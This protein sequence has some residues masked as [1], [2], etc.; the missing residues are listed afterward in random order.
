[1]PRMKETILL[2]MGLIHYSAFPVRAWAAIGRGLFQKTFSRSYSSHRHHHHKPAAPCFATRH[3]IRRR[4]R[5]ITPSRSHTSPLSRSGS[6]CDFPACYLSS[7]WPILAKP[8]MDSGFPVDYQKRKASRWRCAAL[9]PQH[10]QIAKKEPRTS[11]GRCL[12]FKRRAGSELAASR[13]RA[14]PA[15]DRTGRTHDRR[16]CQTD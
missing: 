11:S 2:W 3:R 8:L 10:T 1:M 14:P 13:A 15:W 12:R 9:R 6:A 16:F 4:A 5:S 7:F